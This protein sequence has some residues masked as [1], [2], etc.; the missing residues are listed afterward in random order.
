LIGLVLAGPV[1]LALVVGAGIVVAAVGMVLFMLVF[2]F[3]MAR[4]IVAGMRADPLTLGV[5][6]LAIVLLGGGFLLSISSG[7]GRTWPDRSTEYWGSYGDT[8]DD[9]DD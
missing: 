8:C 7:P 4:D 9:G 6:A 2:T 1:L 3:G 5:V